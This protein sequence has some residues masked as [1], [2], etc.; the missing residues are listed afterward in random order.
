M[1]NF[2]TMVGVPAGP[3]ATDWAKAHGEA[4]SY[5]VQVDRYNDRRATYVYGVA[6]GY[7]DRNDRNALIIPTSSGW[8][9]MPDVVI[10]GGEAFY[11]AGWGDDYLLYCTMAGAHRSWA[12]RSGRFVHMTEV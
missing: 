9:N 7:R 4:F 1:N 6:Y 8:E 3:S 10:Y 12:I 11:L 5:S 2:P